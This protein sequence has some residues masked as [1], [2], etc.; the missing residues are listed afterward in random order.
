M[1]LESLIVGLVI[2]IVALWVGAYA[3]ELCAGTWMAFP[4][5]MTAVGV[6]IAG[7]AVVIIGNIKS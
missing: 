4:A 6:F 2:M 5:F 3:A 1:K 7:S